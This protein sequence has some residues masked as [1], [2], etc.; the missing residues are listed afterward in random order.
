[1]EEMVRYVNTL[2]SDLRAASPGLV[3]ITKDIQNTWFLSLLASVDDLR[4]LEKK[5]F[6][7][8]LQL[9]G[10]GEKYSAIIRAWQKTAIFSDDIE[11]VSPS[12]K[13]DVMRI[14][15]LK[16]MI[17]ELEQQI[18]IKASQSH[19]ASRLRSIKGFGVICCGELAGEIGC[20][21]RFPTD[22]SLALYTGMAALDNS[23]GK[24]RGSKQ[25]KQVNRHAKRAMMVAVDHQRR[26][27]EKSK[28]YYLKKQKEGKKH[29]QAIR[30]LGRHLI[31]IIFKML[32][33]DRDYYL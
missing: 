15:Q 3:D 24:Y 25:S 17:R 2:H 5:R 8:L 31:R 27:N 1:M 18:E 14:I 29:N 32:T 19:L 4:Q 20:V 21:E 26:H 10:V 11:L 16:T 23:S 12:I 7:S 9:N 6:S 22:A 13:T 33:K 28:V 30:S